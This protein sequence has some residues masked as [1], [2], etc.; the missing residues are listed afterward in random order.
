MKYITRITKLTVLPEREPV[1]SEM[2][3]DIEIED[4]AAGEFLKL[5]QHGGNTECEKSILITDDEWPAIRDAIERLLNDINQYK[6]DI[7]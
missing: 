1:F 7:P 2:A 4:E 6:T 3:T 5:T